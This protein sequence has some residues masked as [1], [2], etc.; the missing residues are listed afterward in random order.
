MTFP[1]GGTAIVHALYEKYRSL[2]EGSDDHRRTLTKMMAETFAA[3]FG[4]QWG[5][6]STTPSHPQSKDA[7]AYRH[8]S[9]SVDV[10][11]WQN[12]ATRKPQV[13]DGMPPSA[14]DARVSA[15][16]QTPQH[17]IF[18]EPK[19]HLADVRPEP[20]PPQE[21]HQPPTD[22]DLTD[23]LGMITLSQEPIR[24]ALDSLSHDIAE[25]KRVQAQGLTGR[26][27]G[28]SATFTPPK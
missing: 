27:L 15:T 22:V 17:F 26:V 18:V 20:E 8:D 1:I 12:G 10:F 5:T 4:P 9:G 11:D 21:P 13:R 16:D 19:D 6:K 23:I 3:R 2:A 24:A 7:L 25:I 28:Y 14:A